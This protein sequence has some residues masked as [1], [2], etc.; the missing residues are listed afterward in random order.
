MK[1]NTAVIIITIILILFIGSF[2]IGVDKEEG[3]NQQSTEVE[4]P[5]ST[6]PADSYKTNRGNF[7]VST[8]CKEDVK[9]IVFFIEGH[10]NK[11]GSIIQILG[12]DGFPLTCI[13][14]VG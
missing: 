10:P 3:Y 13:E 7:T 6:W 9:F 4:T 5:I 2:I 8:I 11:A 12:P 14:G 1:N